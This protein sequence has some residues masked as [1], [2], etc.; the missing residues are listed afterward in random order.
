M[1]CPICGSGV[2]ARLSLQPWNRFQTSSRCSPSRPTRTTRLSFFPDKSYLIV[3]VCIHSDISLYLFE[4]RH[5]DTTFGGTTLSSRHAEIIFW[6]KASHNGLDL[7]LPKLLNAEG[8]NFAKCRTGTYR[9]DKA[10]I[11]CRTVF[12]SFEK[13]KIICR[14]VTISLQKCNL[15]SLI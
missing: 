15:E 12:S 1:R 8:A 2:W 10:K 14:T 5:D 9:F 13:A 4:A 7:R 11:M 6:E 3:I